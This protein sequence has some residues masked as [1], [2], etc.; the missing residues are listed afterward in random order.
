LAE[1]F[2]DNQRVYGLLSLTQPGDAFSQD[3]TVPGVERDIAFG[4]KKHRSAFLQ[5]SNESVD[6][7]ARHG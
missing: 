2:G 6:A 3:M 5:E 4:R 7:L 1:G